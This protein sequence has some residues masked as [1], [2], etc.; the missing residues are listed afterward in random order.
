MHV[1]DAINNLRHYLDDFIFTQPIAA[2]GV[3]LFNQV[4]K[5]TS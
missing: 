3:L 5:S 2:L 1:D 4:V